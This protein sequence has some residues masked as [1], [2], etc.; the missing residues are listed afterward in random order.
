M[1]HLALFASLLSLA[2]GPQPSQRLLVVPYQT[3]GVEPAVVARFS[4]A[5]R[6]ASTWTAVNRAAADQWLRAGALCGEDPSCLATL[7][8][9]NSADAVLA[10]SFGKIGSRY[11][12][13][14]ILIESASNKELTRFSESLEALPADPSLLAKRATDELFKVEVAP[15]VAVRPRTLVGPTIGASVVAGV[16]TVTAVIFGIL[17][18]TNYS[19][20][21]KAPVSARAMF[22]GQQRTYN[23]IGDIGLGAAVVSAATALVLFILGAPPAEVP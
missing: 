1:T 23:L 9:E 14:A 21:R 20:L 16:A 7:G 11:L 5:L 22:E 6:G 17:A 2:T 18:A 15:L 4:E 10:W 13:T 12:F 3:V 8:K 19:M